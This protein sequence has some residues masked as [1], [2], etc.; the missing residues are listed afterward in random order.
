MTFFAFAQRAL[1]VAPFILVPCLMWVLRSQPARIRYPVVLLAGWIG[2][3]LCVVLYWNVSVGYATSEVS[4]ADLASRDGAPTA[5]ALLFGWI[6]VA[7]YMPMIEAG[8][9]FF[10]LIGR[11]L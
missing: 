9:M 8:R 3:Y 1:Q 5:A 11:R 10:V 2:L 4:A 7:L 6:F